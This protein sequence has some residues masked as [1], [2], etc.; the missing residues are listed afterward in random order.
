MKYWAG[1]YGAIL[2]MALGL[3]IALLTHAT[4][5]VP[6]LLGMASAGF[7]YMAGSAWWNNL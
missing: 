1:T 3:A 6:F 5:L 2:G 7:G 4:G